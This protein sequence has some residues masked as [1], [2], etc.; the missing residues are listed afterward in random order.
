MSSYCHLVRTV[1]SLC[2]LSHVVTVSGQTC[3]TVTTFNAGLTPR[4]DDYPSRLKRQPAALLKEDADVICVQEYWFENDLA[5]MLKTV[6]SKY[7]Y[8][9]SP[10]H[11]SI[12]YL[13]TLSRKYFFPETAC[14]I[15]DVVYLYRKVLP[16]ARRR[17][18]AFLLLQSLT[19]GLYCAV[20]TCGYFFKTF[21]EDC[22][23]CISLTATYLFSLIDACKPVNYAYNNRL[24]GPGLVLLSKQEILSA[25]YRDFFPGRE[26]TLQRGFIEAEIKDLGTVVCSHFSAT[27]PYYFEYDLDFAN[28]AQ[29][30]QAEM[31]AIQSRFLSRDHILLADFNT[32][33]Q[34][35]TASSEDRVLKGKAPQNFQMWIAGGYNFTY[36]EDDGRCTFCRDNPVV[37]SNIHPNNVIDYVMFKGDYTAQ[38][39]ERTLDE[40]P[41]LSDHYGVRQTLCKNYRPLIWAWIGWSL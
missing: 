38:K 32:G 7:A 13:P 34:V 8:H 40:S 33:P 41:P 24:N 31:A 4:I 5:H 37:D 18:C 12:S 16:C 29:Q 10:L 27:F 35:E 14:N 36:L 11:T 30:Q 1:V 2:V 26:L 20:S 15:P 28:Y 19:K 39:A 3:R 25:K 22:F 17:G 21:S 6:S 23:S 9:F